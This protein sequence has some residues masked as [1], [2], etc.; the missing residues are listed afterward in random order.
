[1]TEQNGFQNRPIHSMPVGKCMFIGAAIGFAIISF[2]VFGTGEPNPEWPK[3]WMIKPLLMV[4]AAGAMGGLFYFNM[5]HLRVEGGWRTVLA[6]FLSLVVF[7]VVLWLGIVLGL[8]GT[9]WD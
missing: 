9:M 3:Y 1:M 8:N 4:P 6:N 2:F 5:D 7:L